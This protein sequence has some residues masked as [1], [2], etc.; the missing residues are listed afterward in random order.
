MQSIS[1]I[2]SSL[3]LSFDNKNLKTSGMIT[4]K[5]LNRE[6]ETPPTPPHKNLIN[7]LPITD[8][9][10]EITEKTFWNGKAHSPPKES[11][12]FLG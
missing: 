7:I 9:S 10:I 12:S 1:P 8:R 3:L 2:N 5:T 4:G 11:T 6:K